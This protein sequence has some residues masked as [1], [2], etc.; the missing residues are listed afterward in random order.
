MSQSDPQT[1]ARALQLLDEALEQPSPERIAWTE[2]RTVG[3][4]ELRSRVLTLLG[5][6]RSLGEA[7]PTGGAFAELED[8]PPPERIG[9]YRIVEK[10][11]QG[12]MGTVYK[13]ERDAGDF[14]HTAA[15]KVIRPG[16]LSD[17]LVERFARERQTLADLAHPHIARL[18]DGGETAEGQPYIV[19]ELV[20]GKPITVWARERGLDVR[21]RLRLFLDACEAV[22]FAHQNLVIHRDITPGNVL[23][24][25][26]GVVKL[27]DFGIARPPEVRASE[28]PSQ[29]SLAGLTLTP[30]FAAPERMQGAGASTLVDVYSLGRLL[31]ALLE[32]LGPDPDL[33]AIVAKAT[34]EAP[35]ARYAGV[36]ALMADV[37]AWLSGRPVAARNGGRR[38]AFGKFVGRH[39]RSV[40]ASAIGVG[41]LIA[42]L[43]V[44]LF[45]YGAAARAREAE[46]R[47]FADLRSLAGFMLFDLNGQLERVAGNTAARVSLAKEAERYL[48]ALAGSAG[49]DET[50]KLEA[51]RG[52]IALAD[53][54]GTPGRPNLGEVEAARRN[55]GAAM[56]LLD[57]VGPGL[58]TAADR[59]QA[60][61]ALA[62]ID[63]HTDAKLD[64]AERRLAAAE[65]ALRT[66]AQAPEDARWRAA[67]SALRRAQLDLAILTQ[68]PERL[69]SLADQL[70][71]EADEGPP[72]A[73][74]SVAA[75][76]DR[77]YADQNR[78]M[79]AWFV[80]DF[81][82]G[83]A[84]A[85]RAERR[86][87]ALDRRRPN[88]PLVL[89]ALAWTSYAGYGAAS[90]APET[91]ERMQRFLAT[92]EATM[93]RLLR[94]EE[95][96]SSLK[97]FTGQ[98]RQARA[99]ALSYEGRHREALA[100]QRETVRLFE[101]A[102]DRKRLSS[103]RN[104]IAGAY[105]TLG[106]IAVEAGDRP[107]ACDSFR[108]ARTML[109]DLERTGELITNL[110]LHKAP[111]DRS[112]RLCASGGPIS[113][114]RVFD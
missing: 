43:I 73:R 65:A 15:I 70:E 28:T 109:A 105:V 7:M 85:E 58:A 42:A 78:A 71:R 98:L 50:L 46:A 29:A 48:T 88:D 75:E 5:V 12:G 89:Y 19:M 4:P 53:V 22:R 3:E 96:D 31:D 110:N 47:R 103:T 13:A 61:T 86:L 83:I 84:S 72:A 36:D 37:R 18:F 57:E 9:A 41:L 67:R 33:A 99:Q 59:V 23:V 102:L 21:A 104:R 44:T 64:A 49:A 55:L 11:G 76:L 1:E 26:A 68:K 32:G 40:A 27:I 94:I 20:P 56:R 2:A 113:A 112:L 100:A 54:Q 38:Y 34:A 45:A 114:M 82:P 35:D 91:A 81:P 51:A 10:L 106:K 24:T 17:A 52:L 14:K 16:A 97:S 60:L 87:L 69:P 107:T 93:D 79:H 63:G 108:R 30:G 25:E 80:D 111:L 77:A 90:G 101:A 39:R 92:A 6:A 74:T 8:A 62:M 66:A 95:N